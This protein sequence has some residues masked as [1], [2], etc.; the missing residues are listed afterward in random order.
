MADDGLRIVNVVDNSQLE[1][2]FKRARNTIRQSADAAVKEGDRIDAIFRKIGTTAASMVAG[3]SVGAFAQKVMQIRGEFQ[4]LEV[5][6]TTMLGSAEKANALMQ[7]LTKTAAITPFDLQGVT[8]GAKQLLAYG[9]EAEKVND[10]LIHLGDIAAGLSIPLNDLVYLYGTTMT[11]GRM[12]TQDLRQFMGRGIPIAE[13]LAKQ[14]GVTKDKVGELVTAGKVGAA[15]FNRAIMAMSSEGGKFAGLMEAQSK[16]INGQI[17]NIEDAVDVMFNNIGKQSEGIINDTLSVVSS[18]VENYEKVGKVIISLVAIYGTYKAAVMTYLA[19]Q[20]THRAWIALE[21][22]AHLQN[23]LATEAEI[24]AKGKATVATVLL[25]KASKMLHATMLANPYVLVATAIAGV[26]VALW[27]MKTQQDLVND[28]EEEY[29][30]KREEAIAKEEKHA[31]KINELIQTASDEQLSTESRRLALIRL[32]QQY[33][34]VFKKYDTEAEKLAHIRDIKNEIAALD[35]MASVKATENELSDVNERIRVLEAKRKLTTTKTR[36]V[37]NHQTLQW[38]RKTEAVPVMTREEEAELR[39]LYGKRNDLSQKQKKEQTENYLKNLTGI[40]NEELQAQINERRNVLSV[41]KTEEKKYGRVRKGGAAGIYT[42]NELEGQ[43]EILEDEQNRRKEKR[44]TPA[45]QRE[46]FL[47]ELKEA[48]KKLRDFDKSSTQYTVG[49]AEKERKRL[50][51]AVETAEK[52]YKAI[53]G[54]TSSNKAD[55]TANEREKNQKDYLAKEDEMAKEREK[56][57]EKLSQSFIDIEEDTKA[58]EL[59]QIKHDHDAEIKE[60]QRQKQ[61]YILKK[62]ELEQTKAKAEGKEYTTPTDKNEVLSD[63][64]SEKFN[65]L[66]SNLLKKIELEDE[67]YLKGATDAM[68]EYLKEYGTYQEQRYAITKE[69]EEKI[70]KARTEGERLK[71]QADMNRDIASIDA[72]RMAMNIDW[73]QT[74]SGVGNVLSDIARDTL[75]EVQAYMEK[76]EFKKLSPEGKKAY[77]D[78]AARLQQEG[79]GEAAS[80]FNFKIW[81]TIAK[82]VEDYQNS[83]IELKAA[84]EAHTQAV[85]N[86]TKAE[87][88]LKEATEDTSK[89]ELQR[90]VD[91]AKNEVNKTS[92][93]LKNAEEG[94]NKAQKDLKDNTEKAT[95]GLQNFTN[96]INEISDGSLFGFANG[97]TKLITGISGVSKGLSEVGGKIGGIVGAILQILDALGDDPAQFIEDLLNRVSTAIEKILEDLPKI[98]GNIVEGVGNIVS[99]VVKGVAGIFGADLTGI[100]GGGTENFDAAVKKWGWLLDTWKDNLDYERSLMKEAYG[101]KVTDIQNKTEAD[102]RRTQQAVAELYRGW[103]SDGGG[104]FSHSNGFKANRNAN[105]D[106]LW[107]QN[108]ELARRMNGDIANLFNL[109]AKDLEELKHNNSQFWQS[110]SEEARNYLDQII[111]IEDELEQLG[112]EALQQ[113]TATSLDSI[114][115]DF[116]H[117]LLDMDTSV[118]D[119]ADHFEEY[120]KNA[121][122]NSLMLSTYRKQL[123]AWYKNFAAAMDSGDELTRAEQESLRQEYESIVKDA[124]RDRDELR[125][126]MGWEGSAYSQQASSKG[127]Q[128]M[129]QDTGEELNGRFTAIQIAVYDIKDLAVEANAYFS[130]LESGNNILGVRVEAIQ[131]AMATSNVHLG[132]I[133]KNTKKMLEFGGIL[134]E[135]RD[136]TKKL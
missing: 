113:L 107:E 106:Y 51:E 86:L 114:F 124:I 9:I 64:E 12:F 83:V 95:N 76:D 37:Y 127:F 46:A 30:R 39:M 15:E 19:V 80:P 118:E 98:I 109:S 42:A 60:F 126:T 136:N 116:E 105:W 34:A 123:E 11:Q 65:K 87:K 32:Q 35:G 22:T 33:P 129:S 8:Q 31:N 5:A 135:I 82:N 40:S 24:A 103:A 112:T 44:M 66:E 7:Q 59:A 57:E 85:E 21:Q 48:Q 117:R 128:A 92:K 43:I 14:F 50:Q 2:G 111:E 63:E 96:A 81:G 62:I 99:G 69:Y 131:T 72:N 71:L 91:A 79:A 45:Q 29:N 25:D 3:F 47:K 68:N 101:S 52:K 16:T 120:M 110:L 75:K 36:N 125:K 49:E 122:I 74:F 23:A 108:P 88:D 4:K 102:L 41:M 61:E 58:R 13:E 70:K 18:L 130:R 77:T 67:D 28:A 97:I 89:A 26:A 1:Q 38:E 121:V 104:W 115:S 84:N 133:A 56:L 134:E 93:D 53:G 73:S 132:N 78:L 55:S 6:F 20:K 54:S 17:S 100:F 94:K 10:T 27:N 90:A 119:L